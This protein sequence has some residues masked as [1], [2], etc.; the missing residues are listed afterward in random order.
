MPHPNVVPFDVRVG[1]HPA[2]KRGDF[3]E[4]ENK[5][6]QVRAGGA[7]LLTLFEKWLGNTVGSEGFRPYAAGGRIFI[8][9]TSQAFT[10]TGPVSVRK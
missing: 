8:F 3:D 10:A 9:S 5:V 7:P 2:T 4:A 6:P 1:F